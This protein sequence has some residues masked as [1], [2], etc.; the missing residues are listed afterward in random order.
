MLQDPIASFLLG[1]S[2]PPRKNY[3][4]GHS[5]KDRSGDYEEGKAKKDFEA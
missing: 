4:R 2:P 1:C 3:R 5:E